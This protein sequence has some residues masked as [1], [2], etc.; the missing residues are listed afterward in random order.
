MDFSNSESLCCTDAS[1]QVL[2]QS[3]FWFG[4][5][6]L[7]NFKMAAMVAIL[8]IGMEILAILNLRVIVMLPIKFWLNLTYGHLGYQ[9]R[10]ISAILNLHVA[11]MQPIKFQLNPTYDSGGDV[12]NRKS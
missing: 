9:N 1:H 6:W 5:C 3:D 10:T 11:T 8:D 4:R 2:V 7:K 12:E